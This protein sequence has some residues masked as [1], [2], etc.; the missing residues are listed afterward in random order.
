[1]NSSWS[2][3]LERGA[4]S[5]SSELHSSLSTDLLLLIATGVALLLYNAGVLHKDSA[6]HKSRAARSQCHQEEACT[7]RDVA[8]C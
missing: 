2:G 7:S 3:G 5:L 1:M 4:N 8:F 6:W